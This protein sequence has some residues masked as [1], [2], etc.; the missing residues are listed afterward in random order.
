MGNLAGLAAPGRLEDAG[1]AR[2]LDH[3]EE[4]PLGAKAGLHLR[5]ER[6]RDAADAG[7]HEDMRR[8]LSVEVSLHL[9]QPFAGDGGVALH[10]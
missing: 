1:G 5:G 9:R 6:S 2:R 3:R 4:R 7:L 8:P 10:H